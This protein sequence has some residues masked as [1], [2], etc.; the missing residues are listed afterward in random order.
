MTLKLVRTCWACPEQYDVFAEN[1]NQI[2]YLRLRH[3]NFRVWCPNA[4]DEMVYHAEPK[5]DGI[6]DNDERE[7]YLTEAIKAIQRHYKITETGF[8]YLEDEYKDDD[9]LP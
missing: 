2:G 9:L 5:G 7:F 8:Y 1:G 3:G 6:F 4:L